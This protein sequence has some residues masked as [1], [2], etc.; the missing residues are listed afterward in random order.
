MPLIKTKNHT[1]NINYSGTSYLVKRVFVEFVLP[2]YKGFLLGIL[3]MLVIAFTT[4]LHA[5]LV[6]PALDEVFGIG[7]GKINFS[8]WLPQSFSIKNSF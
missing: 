3:L 6:Q 1:S 7:G 2:H 4:S 8:D 5:W